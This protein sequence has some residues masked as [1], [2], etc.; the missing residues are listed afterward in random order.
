M[1]QLVEGLLSKI[2]W[3]I[4]AFQLFS[5]LNRFSDAVKTPPS[6]LTPSC[7][8]GSRSSLRPRAILG[9]T[10]FYLSWAIVITAPLALKARSALLGLPTDAWLNIY[11]LNYVHT[12]LF[13]A[14]SGAPSFLDGL[15]FYGQPYSLGLTETLFGV[16]PIYSLFS[17]LTQ[18]PIFSYNL[19]LITALTLNALSAAY[20]TYKLSGSLPAAFAGGAIF[21]FSP[22]AVGQLS[23]LQLL[24]FWWSPLSIL[25]LL[26]Y[27]VGG[28]LKLLAISLLLAVLQ[29]MSSIYLGNFLLTL[30]FLLGASQGGVWRVWR[31]LRTEPGRTSLVMGSFILLLGIAAAPYLLA[32]SYYQ[33]TRTLDENAHFSA[34]LSSY[35][36]VPRGNLLLSFL[37]FP[38]HDP[39][40][41]LFIGSIPLLLLILGILRS[42]GVF[43]RSL[44]AALALVVIFS[45]GPAAHLFGW[46]IPLP[47]GVALKLL[48]P[49]RAMRVPS[50]WGMAYLLVAS[51]LAANGMKWVARR[52]PKRAPLL[53]V[54]LLA[55]QVNKGMDVTPASVNTVDHELVKYLKEGKGGVLFWPAIEVDAP[56]MHGTTVGTLRNAKRSVLATLF[57]RPIVN[58]YS[59][60]TPAG[61]EELIR[62]GRRGPKRSFFTRLRGMGVTT[63]VDVTRLTGKVHPPLC[64]GRMKP[65]SIAGEYNVC[66]LMPTS[67]T[68]PNS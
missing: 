55:E 45:F 66:E 35:F 12:T 5:L 6:S 48:Y 21:G 57:R 13:S 50:R 17:L 10:A 68:V 31:D 38:H 46:S 8:E 58:G 25:F 54:L 27:L 67:P 47:Y 34:A 16:Q 32:N 28:P 41:E 19:L 26:K 2:H 11:T 49:F 60:Y 3:D 15:I 61:Y 1:T 30:L 24:C 7:S 64:G 65:K 51:L 56:T 63:V 37:G 20:C 33:A 36:T 62:E 53:F 43:R 52:W 29:F 9:F 42:E 22:V 44:L 4:R 18:D 14:R 59:G 39:E 40:R 23:H